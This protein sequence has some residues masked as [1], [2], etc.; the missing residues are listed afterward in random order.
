MKQNRSHTV[1]FCGAKRRAHTLQVPAVQPR[2]DPCLLLPEAMGLASTA[3]PRLGHT[4]SWPLATRGYLNVNLKSIKIK[5]KLKFHPSPAL[6]RWQVPSDPRQLGATS[7]TA[8]KTG[9]HQRTEFFQ[10][11]DAG[12]PGPQRASDQPGQWC[13]TQRPGFPPPETVQW[14]PVVKAKTVYILEAMGLGRRAGGGRGVL[15]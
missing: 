15:S 6:T 7:C 1:H 3:G 2:S 9:C 13:K 8:E 12:H 11:M 5:Q 14:S 10:T 4:M